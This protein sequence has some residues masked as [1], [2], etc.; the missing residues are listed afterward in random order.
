MRKIAIM[1]IM[2]IIVMLG[3]AVASDIL[4]GRSRV[5]VF[6]APTLAGVAEEAAATYGAELVDI[7]SVGSVLGVRIIQS[8]NVPDVFMSVDWEL[9]KFI[10][11]RRILDLGRFQLK[12]VCRQ[13]YSLTDI[14]RVRLGV[15]N[16]N[17]APIGYRA[18]AALYWLGVRYGVASAEEISRGL[19]ITYIYDSSSRTVRIDVRG[20][21]ASGRFVARDDLAGVAALLE[22]GAVDCIFAHSPFIISRGYENHF[23]VL[24]V[25]GDID[26]TQ[27]PPVSFTAETQTG[28]IEVKAFRAFAASFTQSGDE[29]LKAL[30]G[31]PLTRYGL[32]KGLG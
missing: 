22:G 20:F 11:P 13:D 28:L 7:R 9:L 8:G 3:I 25:P 29:F 15:A 26:F 6:S 19:N 24:D 17:T 14:G 30:E 5:V 16:P 4:G 27:D 32:L 31:V 12:I 10:K 21:Q 18:L 2:A 1:A 23:K